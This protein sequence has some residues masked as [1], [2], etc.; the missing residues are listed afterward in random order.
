M[1][2]LF[3][4]TRFVPFFPTGNYFERT[5]TKQ[6][7]NLSDNLLDILGLLIDEA[8]DELFFEEVTEED[9]KNIEEA[10]KLSTSDPIYF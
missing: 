9:L 5:V 7:D 10:L 1:K 2:N 6:I 4:D 8:E 3:K